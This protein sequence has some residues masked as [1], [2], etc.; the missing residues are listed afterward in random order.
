[1]TNNH[2]TMGEQFL[3][4]SNALYELEDALSFMETFEFEPQFVGCICEAESE[5]KCSCIDSEGNHIRIQNKQIALTD[6]KNLLNQMTEEYKKAHEEGECD[7]SYRICSDCKEIMTEG[8]C[9]E[10]G[11]AYYCNDTCLHKHMSQEHYDELY[12]EGEG[13]SYWTSWD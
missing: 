7:D 13:D 1:M 8:Y 3:L 9:I 11:L 10:N 5:N 6:L 4:V 2:L 12:A